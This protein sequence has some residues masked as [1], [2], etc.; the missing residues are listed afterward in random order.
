MWTDRARPSP[1]SAAN[2][3]PPGAHL[4]S[5]ALLPVEIIRDKWERAVGKGAASRHPQPPP[6]PHS[7]AFALP[8]PHGGTFSFCLC[9]PSAL[10][11]L[12]R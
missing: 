11:Q 10:C 4:A 5:L 1:P 8:S 9:F 7:L 2:G 6:P 12:G 3:G